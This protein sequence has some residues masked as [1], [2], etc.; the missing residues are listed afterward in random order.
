MVVDTRNLRVALR[1][2][3]AALK[4]YDPW[5]RLD[6]INSLGRLGRKAGRIV[7]ALLEA[8][9]DD[10]AVIR[11]HAAL[12]LGE[13]GSQTAIRPL[14]RA[15]HDEDARVRRCAL[16]SLMNLGAETTVAA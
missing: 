11:Q 14:R 4:C 10:N 13:I 9:E 12:A 3:N 15:L 1:D 8:L 16:L 5:V 6:A 2:L 7:P